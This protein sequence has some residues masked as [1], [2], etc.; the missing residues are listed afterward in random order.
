[1]TALR[2]TLSPIPRRPDRWQYVAGGIIAALLL[3]LLLLGCASNPKPKPDAKIPAWTN[4][5]PY[6]GARWPSW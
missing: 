6:G 4:A 1:M 5:A 3:A 2:N